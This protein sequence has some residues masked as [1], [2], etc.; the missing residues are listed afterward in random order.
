MRIFF[1]LLMV[2]GYHSLRFFTLSH[3]PWSCYLAEGKIENE[4]NVIII[5]Y[6]AIE[7]GNF[8]L[9]CYSILALP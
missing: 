3:G 5:K 2:K 1:A 6:E 9:S 8:T 7:L 4:S